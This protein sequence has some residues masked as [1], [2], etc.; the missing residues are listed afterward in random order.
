MLSLTH[1]SDYPYP[2]LFLE[3]IIVRLAQLICVILW[4]MTFSI[5]DRS[6]PGAEISCIVHTQNPGPWPGTWHT[7]RCLI[8]I[9]WIN[10]WPCIGIVVFFNQYFTL[11]DFLKSNQILEGITGTLCVPPVDWGRTHLTRPSIVEH[12]SVRPDSSHPFIHLLV[13][14]FVP[15]S[16]LCVSIC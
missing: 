3:C 9:Y 2:I 5:V 11:R 16:Y 1:H 12:F 6:R 14:S 15:L 7:V 8:K 10:G 4:L 13:N